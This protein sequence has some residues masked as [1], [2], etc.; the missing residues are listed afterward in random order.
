MKERGVVVGIEH[1]TIKTPL[2]P[3]N[4]NDKQKI[5]IKRGKVLWWV[6]ERETRFQ[7]T[8]KK[9]NKINKII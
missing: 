7:C 8:K 9:N 5:K 3:T 2:L 6:H 1:K 4:N